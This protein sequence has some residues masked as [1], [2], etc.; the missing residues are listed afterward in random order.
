MTNSSDQILDEINDDEKLI[1]A[2]ILRIESLEAN[3]RRTEKSR[4]HIADDDTDFNTQHIDE[5]NSFL[6]Q[7]LRNAEVTMLRLHNLQRVRLLE[8]QA[9]NITTRTQTLKSDFIESESFE[10]L[11]SEIADSQSA[12]VQSMKFKKSI[13]AAAADALLLSISLSFKLKIIKSEKM[14]TYKSQSENEH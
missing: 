4:H 11:S 10:V 12:S 13:V 9:Q 7:Q 2:Q 8:Q 1:K 6:S 5:I 14:R 3:S